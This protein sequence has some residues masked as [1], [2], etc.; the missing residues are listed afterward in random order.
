MGHG[1]TDGQSVGHNGLFSFLDWSYR[2]WVDALRP[3][4]HLHFTGTIVVQARHAT[5]EEAD[6][7][8]WF[9]CAQLMVN[10]HLLQQQLQSH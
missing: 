10:R 4:T 6:P 8:D 5:Q 9:Q 2:S 7:F 3:M 1:G